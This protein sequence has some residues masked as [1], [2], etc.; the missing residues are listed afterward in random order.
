MKS[1]SLLGRI[2]V[3]LTVTTL[4]AGLCTYGWLYLKER[5]TERSLR[6]ETLLDQAGV[7]AAYLTVN[8]AGAIELDLPPRLA[9]VYLNPKSPFRYA[10]H[11]ESGQLMFTS[12]SQVQALPLITK[13]DHQIYDY[14]PDGPGPVHMF[15]AAVQTILGGKTLFT[16]LE[17]KSTE[18]EYLNESVFDEFLTD[19]IWL[20]I[21]FLL[22]ML[23][24]SIWIVKR[25]VKPLTNVSLLAESIGPANANVRLPSADVPREVLPLVR[26]LN[27]AL[28]RLEDGLQLQRGFNA[29]AAHQLRTPLAVLLANID[30]LDDTTIA[31]RL[32]VDVEHM[33]RIVSQLLLVSKLQTLSIDLTEVFELNSATAEI[34]A[35]LAPLAIASFKSMELTKAD[36]PI[37]I[38]GSSFA[39]RE[40]L[41]NLIENAINHTPAGTSVR[42]R[43]RNDPA[44][45]VIDS[46]PGVPPE[47]QKRIFERFWRGDHSKNGAGLGLAIVEQI[48]KALGGS[49][50]VDDNPAG[51]ARFT[52]VFP[53][54]SV[55]TA[56]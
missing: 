15:G 39:L 54:D 25:A 13:P 23:S 2:T 42:L 18:S 52:L 14:D 1:Y 4:I 33:G 21:P 35:K 32:R 46:G 28:D 44:V 51:G 48:M 29:D 55:I 45:E 36:R 19:G 31:N 11:D 3:S 30:A 8:T 26:A 41:G 49:V 47:Q 43:V 24:I 10:V 12:G 53:R 37:F 56:I 7:I 20:Q 17:Q 50:A 6:E 5:S 9:E 27:S 38:R 40:A 16:Q 22:L 34:A